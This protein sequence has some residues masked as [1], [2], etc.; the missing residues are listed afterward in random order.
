MTATQ[1]KTSDP[2]ALFTKAEFAE[3]QLNSHV[4]S[5][6]AQAALIRTVERAERIDVGH[7]LIF[8]NAIAREGLNPV[9][10]RGV[11]RTEEQI[12][13][14]NI[15]FGKKGNLPQNL[16]ISFSMLGPGHFIMQ[17]LPQAI[18]EMC[19]HLEEQFYLASFGETMSIIP[20][21]WHQS[22][23]EMSQLFDLQQAGSLATIITSTPERSHLDDLRMAHVQ[24][25]PL[26]IHRVID[27]LTKEKLKKTF[28][29]NIFSQAQAN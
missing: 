15:F 8:V 22:L 23:A 1:E 6:E 29:E 16:E 7:G 4:L 17:G 5:E 25:V 14:G 19:D 9:V 12:F 26:V 3:A 21:S 27:H 20:T 28:G 10:I 24:D 18:E 2:L 13:S 11:V